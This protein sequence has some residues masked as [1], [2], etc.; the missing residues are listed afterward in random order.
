MCRRD[1]AFTWSWDHDDLPDRRVDIRVI[2]DG[3]DDCTWIIDH[4]AGDD[5][6]GAGYL[7]G[8]QNFL[9]KL[10]AVDY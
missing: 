3:D 8:W 6:E 2:P 4:E 1:R 9:S 7:E 5:D 10:T